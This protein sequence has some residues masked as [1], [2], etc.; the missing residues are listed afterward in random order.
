MIKY[1]FILTTILITTLLANTNPFKI[2]LINKQ[3][4][5]RMLLGN[6]FKKGCPVPLKDL[7]Y[8]SI[9]HLGFDGKDKIGELIVH[10]SV[11]KEVLKIFDELYALKYPI[12]KM[13]LVSDYKAD[14]WVSIEDNNTSAFNCRAITGKKN[15]WSKHA[16]G[17][18]I[19]IN[20]IENPYISRK[21]HI[22]HKD[23]L[24]YRTRKHEIKSL[25]DKAVLLKNSKVVKIFE[26]HGW[27][28]GGDWITIKDYQ[29]FEKKLKKEYK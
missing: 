23:S 22:S 26:K 29:H 17:K 1:L 11:A 14:D 9:K 12:Y 6:S 8:L 25:K 13:K 10:K 28:W 2:S 4:E 3:I 15:K 21:G 24:K 27:K 20:P 7:R 16:Y 5:N 19:D 18:A